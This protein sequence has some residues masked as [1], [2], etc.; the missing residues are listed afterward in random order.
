[1]QKV[2]S[3]TNAQKRANPVTERKDKDSN[4][5]STCGPNPKYPKKSLGGGGEGSWE[6]VHVKR[7]LE[8]HLVIYPICVC[9]YVYISYMDHHPINIT[10]GNPS[11]NACFS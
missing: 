1:M 4:D 11:K 2:S 3:V 6:A 5:F 8:L 7:I 9:M 10:L